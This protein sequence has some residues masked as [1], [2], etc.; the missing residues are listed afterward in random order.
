MLF[1]PVVLLPTL[2]SSCCSWWSSTLWKSLCLTGVTLWISCS[3][4]SFNFCW[5]VYD[6]LL[7]A[8]QALFKCSCHCLRVVAVTVLTPYTFT[9]IAAHNI[10]IIC[11]LSWWDSVANCLCTLASMDI[12]I[13][14]YQK[15]FDSG[16]NPL[17]VFSGSLRDWSKWFCWVTSRETLQNS[18]TAPMTMISETMSA[19]VVSPFLGQTSL[20]VLFTSSVVI[21]PWISF[22]CLELLCNKSSCLEKRCRPWYQGTYV[23]QLSNWSLMSLTFTNFSRQFN[24]SFTNPRSSWYNSSGCQTQ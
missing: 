3:N 18:H 17:S 5:L 14:C 23:N 7:L 21:I 16:N 19:S 9:S 2:C 4:H 20:G 8:S 13:S 15:P 24:M 6:H 11:N 1:Q 10:G 22:A 12:N